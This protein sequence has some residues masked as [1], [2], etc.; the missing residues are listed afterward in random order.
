[1]LFKEGRE[2]R[3]MIMLK[4]LKIVVR[5]LSS[6]AVLVSDKYI[7]DL[8]SCSFG[9]QGARQMKAIRRKCSAVYCHA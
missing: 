3:A 2:R 6:V 5:A 9:S 1:M 7:L 4:E 8:E